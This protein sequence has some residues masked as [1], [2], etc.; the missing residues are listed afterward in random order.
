MKKIAKVLALFALSSTMLVGCKSSDKGSESSSEESSQPEVVKEWSSADA[1]VMSDHLH[2]IVLPF[3]D[4]A[5]VTVTWNE[6]KSQV[7]ID[8]GSADS[9][10]LDSYKS[11]FKKADGW[12]NVSASGATTEFK[13]EK[14]VS[15]S[16]GKRSVRV[17]ITLKSGNLSIVASDPF[18]YEW[19]SADVAK[20]VNDFY[21]NGYEGEKTVLPAISG[22]RFDWTYTKSQSYMRVYLDEEPAEE[23]AGYSTILQNASFDL[24]EHVDHVYHEGYYL[25]TAPDGKF[26]VSYKYEAEAGYFVIQLQN[27]Q[28]D[29]FPTPQL[30]E[31]LGGAFAVPEF[32]AEDATY[33]FK[34]DA[35]RAVVYVN[36][37][38][39]DAFN[40]Y[41]E[42][43]LGANGWAIEYDEMY[44]QYSAYLVASGSTYEMSLFFVDA[45]STMCAYA[46]LV[47]YKKG[48]AIK[49]PAEDIASYLGSG[50][51]DVLPEYTNAN[52]T[53]Y[54]YAMNADYDLLMFN[55]HTEAKIEATATAYAAQL[56]S[57]GWHAVENE[58]YPGY[59]TSPNNQFAIQ[60]E[61]ELYVDYGYFVVNFVDING[62]PQSDWP[63]AQVAAI[64]N[65]EDDTVPAL[66]GALAYVPPVEGDGFYYVRCAYE[67]ADAASAALAEYLESIA[68]TWTYNEEKGAYYT[69]NNAVGLMAIVGDPDENGF[70]ENEVII[71]VI[72][73]PNFNWPEAKIAAVYE[74]EHDVVPALAG[75]EY[76]SDPIYYEDWN[77]YYVAG[78]YE[79]TEAAATA[80]GNW[81]ASLDGTWTWNESKYWYLSA[82]GELG[83]DYEAEENVVYIYFYLMP[84]TT[85]E[86]P[87]TE[88]A[89]AVECEHDVFP[90]LEGAVEYTFPEDSGYG[91]YS[92]SATFE[93]AEAAAEA[94]GDYMEGLEGSWEYDFNHNWLISENQELGIDVSYTA[95]DDYITFYFAEFESIEVTHYNSFAEFG[96]AFAEISEVALAVAPSEE[97]APVSVDMSSAAIH[98]VYEDAEAAEAALASLQAQLA[99]EEQFWDPATIYYYFGVYAYLSSD[100]AYYVGT[101]QYVEGNVLIVTYMLY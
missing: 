94:Y 4:K 2:G 27:I 101:Q 3:L 44:G 61:S 33:E 12:K 32:E 54:A 67:D 99:D 83:I 100:F 1:Q 97:G 18:I 59:Y 73:A 70:A 46:G 81:A 95:E 20:G 64:A 40:D 96:T 51:T 58:Y 92:F 16:E 38:S 87:A 74:A 5:G 8:G 45:T 76:Y 28:L 90:A 89:A 14:T 6:T 23:D 75:A 62:V 36:F 34:S 9:A 52:G 41:M 10:A 43:D 53:A 85:D 80:A 39:E 50:I 29:D 19:P 15:V 37:V 13:F 47:I 26:D 79:T 42:D 78:V 63:T 69:E 68:D 60:L 7:E 11:L 77:C 35:T 66:N 48:T 65:S 82:N 30:N 55:C 98:F 57:A 72:P 17:V 25:A 88:I 84:T 71:G 56:A 86:W 24:K 49:W 93:D 21:P 22:W 31:Y 91:Y